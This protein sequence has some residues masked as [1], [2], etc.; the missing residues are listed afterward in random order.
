MRLPITWIRT[1]KAL[2]AWLLP[3]AAG[4]ALLAGCAGPTPTPAPTATPTASPTATAKPTPTA[5]STGYAVQVYVNG[6]LKGRITLDMVKALPSVTLPG[7]PSEHGPTLLSTLAAAGV[8]RFSQVTIIGLARGR[9]QPLQRTIARADAKDTVIL[10]VTGA[11]TIKLSSSDFPQDQWVLD[12]SRMDVT[13]GA[14]ETPV[15]GYTLQVLLKGQP[16]A[17]LTLDQLKALPQT[18]IAAQGVQQGP[19][20]AQV[21]KA[22]GVTD[23]AKVTAVG[24]SMGRAGPGQRTLQKAEVT[25]Q[26]VLDLT[27]KNTTK[28]ASTAFPREQWVIDVARLEVE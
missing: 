7:Y 20:L 13:Q 26:T 12:I 1:P 17:S 8:D 2:A 27:G 4:V 10:D 5:T 6:A 23:Y 15:V 3:L 21:L 9:T 16:K 25:D 22:A 18:T 14:G 19:A 11:G 28:L 24:L